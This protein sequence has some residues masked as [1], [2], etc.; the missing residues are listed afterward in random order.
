MPR[1]VLLGV[2][3]AGLLL[4][5]V[6]VLLGCA[7]QAVPPVPSSERLHEGAPKDPPRPSV[8]DTAPEEECCIPSFEGLRTRVLEPQWL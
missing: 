8:E 5:I 2:L 7:P 6:T 4:L 3:A 1:G